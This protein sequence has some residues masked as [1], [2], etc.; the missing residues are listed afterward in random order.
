MEFSCLKS[1]LDVEQIANYFPHVFTERVLS[2]CFFSCTASSSTSFRSICVLTLKHRKN[3]N[4]T[5]TCHSTIRFQKLQ[6][7]VQT[8]QN[9]S[10]AFLDF[11]IYYHLRC[12]AKSWIL[13]RP[14]VMINVWEIQIRRWSNEKHLRNESEAWRVV[15]SPIAVPLFK[16]CLFDICFLP[17]P[18]VL[19]PDVLKHE[20]S[21]N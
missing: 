21:H 12:L 15:S 17:F 2:K 7:H 13:M 20:F 9:Y 16:W 10:N 3:L 18:D 4:F 14:S 8:S 5:R 19:W 1:L 6:N 11:I